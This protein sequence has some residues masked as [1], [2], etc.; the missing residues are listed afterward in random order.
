MDEKVLSYL[1]DNGKNVELT[2]KERK[3]IV[4]MARLLLNC[5]DQMKREP[6]TIDVYIQTLEQMI[7]SI[8]NDGKEVNKEEETSN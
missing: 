4:E 6:R 3:T 8:Q 5:L 1:L 7:Y 2:E